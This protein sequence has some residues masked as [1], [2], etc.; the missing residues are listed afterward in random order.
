MV[1][2]KVKV[3]KNAAPKVNIATVAAG[4]GAKIVDIS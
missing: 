2:R 1:G 4:L 3:Q